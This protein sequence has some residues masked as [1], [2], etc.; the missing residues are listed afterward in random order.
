[1]RERAIQREG[2]RDGTGNG[3]RAA[4]KGRKG[5]MTDRERARGKLEMGEKCGEEKKHTRG[6][7]TETGRFARE[8]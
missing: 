7:K 6:R 5:G 2:E 3:G 1:M 4:L 8:G